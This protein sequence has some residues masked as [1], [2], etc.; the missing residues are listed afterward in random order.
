[1]KGL[2]EGGYQRGSLGSPG[3]VGW[4]G[5]PFLAPPS[6]SIL[7]PTAAYRHLQNLRGRDQQD[8]LGLQWLFGWLEGFFREPAAYQNLLGKD[9][10]DPLGLRWLFGWLEG[11]F[12]ERNLMLWAVC[13]F[14]TFWRIWSREWTRRRGQTAKVR[15]FSAT[16]C[17]S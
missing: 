2:V 13:F 16:G 1:M 10:Q 5:G 7:R 9:R 12:R 17:S 8:P 11:F 15:S 3:M 6:A 14:G 4:Q